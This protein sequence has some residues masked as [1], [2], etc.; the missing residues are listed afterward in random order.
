MTVELIMIAYTLGF[1]IGSYFESVKHNKTIIA[2]VIQIIT[3]GFLITWI[4]FISINSFN[5]FIQQDNSNQQ[6]TEEVTDGK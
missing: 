2:Y 5:K 6:T 3:Y 1:F 4:C